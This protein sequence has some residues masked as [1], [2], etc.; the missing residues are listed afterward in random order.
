M[1]RLS[2]LICLL[3]LLP[4]LSGCGSGEAAP[5]ELPANPISQDRLKPSNLLP[6]A[7]PALRPITSS[8]APTPARPAAE[9]PAKTPEPRLQAQNQTPPVGNAEAGKPQERQQRQERQGEA[10]KEMRVRDRNND[11]NNRERPPGGRQEE[12][13]NRGNRGG[14]DGGGQG[15]DWGGGFEFPAG[16]PA[17]NE[18]PRY[19]TR[20]LP[21]GMPSW[22][23][24]RDRDGDGQIG[25]Y[26]WPRD[27]MNEF[28]KYDR[29]GDGLIT[30]EEGLRVSNPTAIAAGN[31]A[32]GTP[33]TGT[34]MASAGDDERLR[35]MVQEMFLRQ[36]DR[37]NDRRLDAQ[38]VQN[39]RSLRTNWQEYDANRDNG[40]DE[41]ELVAWMRTRGPGSNFMAGNFGGGRPG[42]FRG[43][44]PNFGNFGGGMPNFGGGMPN[45]GGPGGGRGGRGGGRGAP[46]GDWMSQTPEERARGM[47][48]RMDNNRDG[49]LTQQE[50]TG[51]FGRRF[52][53]LDTNR[54]GAVDL[55][56]LTAGMANMGNRGGGPGGGRGR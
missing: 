45:F 21:A 13:G 40:L 20:P 35:R 26:E 46:G 27:E 5:A 6:P 16:M 38:E 28:V 3:W 56:E 9:P 10:R 30:V 41:T 37:N 32:P 44:M 15:L 51:G 4:S 31:A 12:R 2:F 54:D 52:P 39:T 22:F 42:D 17:R 24:E 29:N 53:E 25:M 34:S 7:A 19:L 8:P 55:Q 11:N 49:R 33:G 48:D 43:G 47:L 18:K 50:M 36:Y 1:R 14:A 23:G